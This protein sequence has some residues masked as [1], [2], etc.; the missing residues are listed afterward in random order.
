MHPLRAVNG[1]VEPPWRDL[2]AVNVT[3]LAGDGDHPL[4]LVA[5]A[6]LPLPADGQSASF[7]GQDLGDAELVALAVREDLRRLDLSGN[8]LTDLSSL[9]RFHTLRSL[10]LSDNAISNLAPLRGLTELR[11]LDLAGNEIVDLWPLTDLPNLEVL[12]LDGNRV[13]EIGVLTHMTRLE[14]LGLS[15]N[16]VDD[17]SPLAD[18]W[19]L[20]RLDLGR[21]PTRDLSPVGDLEA[22]VWLRVPEHAGEAPAHRLGRLRW[23]LSPDAPGACLGCS[24]FEAQE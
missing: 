4:A 21:N 11:R 1:D 9:T 3:G 17:L 12:L 22:L 23:L 16:A 15:G 13:A 7:A 5:D 8:A 14:N 10:D 24:V 2:P 20:R 19:S 6:A 18:L